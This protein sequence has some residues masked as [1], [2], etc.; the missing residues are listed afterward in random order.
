M[1]V[2]L[3]NE[4]GHDDDT[5]PA[6]TVPQHNRFRSSGRATAKRGLFLN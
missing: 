3:V 2:A 5:N 1:D 4:P 6:T